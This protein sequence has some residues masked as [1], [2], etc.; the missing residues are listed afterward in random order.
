[1]NDHV[2]LITGSTSGIG[3]GIAKHFVKIGANVV[4]NGFG[5]KSEI[6]QITKV[7]LKYIFSIKPETHTNRNTGTI[8]IITIR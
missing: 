4:L 7:S 5:D 8:T 1:M 2:I 3:L 6:D